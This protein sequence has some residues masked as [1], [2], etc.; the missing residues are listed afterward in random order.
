MPY[1]SRSAC[2]SSRMEGRTASS[3]DDDIGI[4]VK[5]AQF[6]GVDDG[7]AV[8]TSAGF[9]AGGVGIV[10]AAAFGSGIVGDHRVDV[11][12]GD[13]KSVARLAEFHVIAVSNRL[14]DDA[15]GKAQRLDDARDD[16]STKAGVVHISVPDDINKIK[17]FPA[18][19]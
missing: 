10:A 4:G 3:T 18:A 17:L 8:G 14:G 15:D 13:Q 2:E 9:A 7:G 1:S 19:L 5:L 11:A 6:V 12:A 16:S